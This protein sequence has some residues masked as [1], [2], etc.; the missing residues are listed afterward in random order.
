MAGP[1]MNLFLA[2]VAGLAI[3]LGLAAEV[4]V[5]AMNFQF[6][7]IVDAT[8][9]GIWHG[10]ATFLSIA[11]MLNV[12]LLCFN[13]LPLPPLDGS[14][15]IPAVLNYEGAARY[16]NMVSQPAVS[17]FGIVIAWRVFGRYFWNVLGFA[18]GALGL[19]QA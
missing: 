18:L 8:N 14:W 17:L 2:V 6:S 3:R 15:L 9:P 7:Q 11:F 5:P 1:G 10:V 19:V 4:F 13:L 12:I 16:W